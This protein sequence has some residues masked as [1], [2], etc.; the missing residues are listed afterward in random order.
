MK[1]ASSPTVRGCRFSKSP[2]LLASK[3]LPVP[4]VYVEDLDRGIIVLEDLG[5]LTFEQQLRHTPREEWPRLYEGAIDLLADLHERCA[6][7]PATSIVSQRSFDRELLEWEP[8]SFSR[9]GAR[10]PPGSRSMPPKRRRFARRPASIVRE[11]EAMPYG[12]VHRDYQS[13]NLMVGSTGALTL[14]DF[15]R[16]ASG[17]SRLRPRRPALRFVRVAFPDL[18]NE[19]LEWLDD[20]V[21]ELGIRKEVE[22]V[23]VILEHGTSADRQLRVYEE[24]GSFEAV[25]DHLI[26][27]TTDF[28]A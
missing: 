14:I 27:E 3:G 6:D 25:V 17:P 12:F 22:H 5:D 16:R 8:R 20:V 7:L 23:H 1:G 26:E 21:D 4:S 19:M 9:V 18:A 24:T 28:D 15:S 2:R 10:G 13:K 11:I